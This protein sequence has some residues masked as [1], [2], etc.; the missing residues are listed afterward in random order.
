MYNWGGYMK[1]LDIISNFRCLNEYFNGWKL[2]HYVT[3][4]KD[5]KLI[6]KSLEDNPEAVQDW[7]APSNRRMYRKLVSMNASR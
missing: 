2:G 1:R 4:S 3:V 6:A 5:C 7:F